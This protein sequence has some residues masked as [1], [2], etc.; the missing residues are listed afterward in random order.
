MAFD[1]GISP[2][3]A[4]RRR[5]LLD[6]GDGRLRDGDAVAFAPHAGFKELR[7]TAQL[8]Y[9]IYGAWQ[10]VGVVSQGQL[11]HGA[12]ESPLARQSSAVT[13]ALGFVYRF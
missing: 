4:E 5:E 11:G 3:Q 6:A 2:E 7:N 12:A 1:F 9:A 13:T 10:V 8:G